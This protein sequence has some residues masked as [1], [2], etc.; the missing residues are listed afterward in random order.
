MEESHKTGF[1]LSGGFIRGFAHLGA[2]QALFEEG[3]R[4]DIV[5]G[6]S[7][8][9]LAG[10]FIADGREPRDVLKLFEEKEFGDFTKFAFRSKGGIMLLDQFQEFLYNNL[11]VHNIE[12]L[13]I[14]FMV[15]ATNLDAG[16]VVHFREGSIVPRVAASC[17]VPGLFTPINIDGE[18]H[19]DGGVFM[20][21]PVATI[22]NMCE[23][24]VA[25]NVSTI[26]QKEAGSNML[27]V[28]YRTYTLMSHSNAHHDRRLADILIEPPNLHGYSNRELDKAGEIFETGYNAARKVLD[29]VKD[30]VF[31]GL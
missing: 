27:S 28:M 1:A 30:I 8:G 4:P 24:V 9:A 11:S 10:V 3:V 25:V 23:K 5:S 14:P 20:N 18:R 29:Q 16:K 19:I 13:K 6:V 12:E 15:T 17:C 7:A 31:P 22:R 2:M 21:L 26:V